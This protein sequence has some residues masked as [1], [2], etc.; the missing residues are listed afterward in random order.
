MKNNFLYLFVLAS[1]CSCVVEEKKEVNPDTGL[2]W[3]SKKYRNGDESITIGDVTLRGSKVRYCSTY[4]NWFEVWTDSIR[5]YEGAK[6]SLNHLVS[7][8]LDEA[9]S[10]VG[11]V[12]IMHDKTSASFRFNDNIWFQVN[13]HSRSPYE[14]NKDLYL[15]NGAYI[16][17]VSRSVTG[18]AIYKG[19]NDDNIVDYYLLQ[20]FN[21]DEDFTYTGVYNPLGEE[22]VPIKYGWV[23]H[24]FWNFVDEL[25]NNYYFIAH[26]DDYVNVYSCRGDL[27]LQIDNAN[28]IY[29]A[30]G[31]QYS[32]QDAMKEYRKEYRYETVDEYNRRINPYFNSEYIYTPLYKDNYKIKLK[33]IDDYCSLTN[34]YL[35]K[36]GDS[37]YI[38]RE[39]ES[40]DD[41]DTIVIESVQIP[42]GN[43][44]PGEQPIPSSTNQ[45]PYN[46]Y[47]G[48]YNTQLPSSPG[49]VVTQPTRDED[50][51]MWEKYYRDSYKR[52][53]DRVID[54]FASLTNQLIRNDGSSTSLNAISQTKLGIGKMQREMRNLRVEAQQ[55]HNVIIHPSH[56]ESESY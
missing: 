51:S 1:L 39:S 17:T 16:A 4:Q 22:L 11:V 48:N 47:A 37:F 7:L 26:K 41:Y 43:N 21:E 34:Y 50:N 53:E 49:V 45:L 6:A 14:S 5:I 15:S 30:S 28:D 20:N 9:V 12:F 19:H 42:I 40:I 27:L 24:M 35:S 10:T 8:P 54:Y 44:M 13:H 56:W 31:K 32:M 25:N 55:Q 38:L 18:V 46:G 36:D 29:V 3:I 23:R 2:E 33:S 52:Y